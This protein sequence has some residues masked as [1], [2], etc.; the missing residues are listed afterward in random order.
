MRLFPTLFSKMKYIILFYEQT[1][2]IYA[3]MYE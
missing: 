3:L 1:Y 2:L